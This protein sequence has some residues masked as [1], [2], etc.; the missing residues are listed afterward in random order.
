MIVTGDWIISRAMALQ[1]RHEAIKLSLEL[2][3][4]DRRELEDLIEVLNYQISKD[5]LSEEAKL[6]LAFKQQFISEA[7]NFS[8]DTARMQLNQMEQKYF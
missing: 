4:S 8:R 1:S 2:S 3:D 6:H 7:I 5:S